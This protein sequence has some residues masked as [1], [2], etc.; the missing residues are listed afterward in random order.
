[1]MRDEKKGYFM[2]IRFAINQIGLNVQY[3]AHGDWRSAGL[4]SHA[5][6][7]EHG[8]IG[9]LKTKV[10]YTLYPAMNM[11]QDIVPPGKYHE[12]GMTITCV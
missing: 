6:I 4:Y 8:G 7:K 11:Q 2:K 5:A 1:M 10:L 12:S 3:F 9:N